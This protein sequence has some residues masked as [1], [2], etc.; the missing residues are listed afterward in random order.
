MRGKHLVSEY[1]PT[2][3]FID[4]AAD[5]RLNE[6]VQIMVAGGISQLRLLFVSLLLLASNL[7]SPGSW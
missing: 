2:R 4:E 3:L 7:I 6:C 5:I 1:P